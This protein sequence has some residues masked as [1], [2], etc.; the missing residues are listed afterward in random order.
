M[1]YTLGILGSGR[2][3]VFLSRVNCSGYG[4]NL[5]YFYFYSLI[6]VLSSD[7]LIVS[8]FLQG[9]VERIY[10]YYYYFPILIRL[11][12]KDSMYKSSETILIIMLTIGRIVYLENY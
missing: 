3:G 11:E 7:I 4:I 6:R 12:L 8:L 9:R 2:I 5:E 10:Y 1:P